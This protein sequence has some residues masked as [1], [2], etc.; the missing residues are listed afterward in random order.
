MPIIV[1]HDDRWR[2]AQHHDQVSDPVGGL[3]HGPVERLQ[4]SVQDITAIATLRFAGISRVLVSRSRY[5]IDY[6]DIL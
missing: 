4:R 1:N 3:E 6:S 2:F 5:G